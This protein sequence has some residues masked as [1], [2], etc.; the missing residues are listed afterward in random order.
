LTPLFEFVPL[1]LRITPEMPLL[2]FMPPLGTS[3]PTTP[4]FFGTLL[5]PDE[6]RLIPPRLPLRMTA[7]PLPILLPL[8]DPPEGL[9]PP[10]IRELPPLNPPER[11]PPEFPPWLW[12]PARTE[13]IVPQALIE[14][15]KR[16]ASFQLRNIEKPFQ[17][18]ERR[19]P[20]LS[21]PARRKGCG[22]VSS[23]LAGK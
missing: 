9:N 6:P 7:A 22:N 18:R 2:L 23:F 13:P 11:L 8:F 19:E 16:I 17:V 20:L 21:S 3:G 1:M 15:A 12:P 5:L 4:V 10:D 14:I